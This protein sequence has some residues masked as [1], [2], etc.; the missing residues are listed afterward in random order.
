[1]LPLVQIIHNQPHLLCTM[2]VSASNDPIA[3]IT[4]SISPLFEELP[5]DSILI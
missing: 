5:I 1:M 4:L 3:I 2:G